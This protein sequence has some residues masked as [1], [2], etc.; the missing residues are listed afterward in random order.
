MTV[1]IHETKNELA[2]QLEGRIQELREPKP[3]RRWEAGSRSY[4]AQILLSSCDVTYVVLRESWKLGHNRDN[5]QNPGP[6]TG[7]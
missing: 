3:S 5:N 7:R 1:F 4:L 2:D 6:G